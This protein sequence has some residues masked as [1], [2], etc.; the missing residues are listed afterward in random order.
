LLLLLLLL[1]C[2]V[3][4]LR[5]VAVD[6]DVVVALLV[7]VCYWTLFGWLVGWLFV[8]IGC[9]VVV[10]RL[11]YVGLFVVVVRYCLVCLLLLAL[12]VGC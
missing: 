3:T 6:C 10:V 2:F 7:V 9:Y 1:F 11:C 8:D 4:L 5:N 12:F